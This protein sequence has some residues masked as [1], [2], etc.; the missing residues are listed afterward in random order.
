MK[1]REIRRLPIEENEPIAITS[2]KVNEQSVSFN[3]K[4]RADD[5][6]LS[7]LVISIKNKSDK[8]ILFASIRLQF[9]PSPSGPE[10]ISIYDM[11][12]G[13]AAL[14]TRPPTAEERVVGFGP[15][16]TFEISLSP[17]QFRGFRDFL[18][19][20]V[21]SSSIEKVDL[22]LSHVIFADDTMWYAGSQLRRDPKDPSTWLNSR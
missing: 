6:W 3:K 22:S 21:H 14:P 2:I 11:A 18:S 15:G 4:F 8:L 7:G 13:N 9:P 19:A 16:E 17:Q 5:E 10:R 1:E 12:Q 20:T